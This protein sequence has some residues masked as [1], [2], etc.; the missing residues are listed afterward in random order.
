MTAG[1]GFSLKVT[2]LD[3]FGN[4]ATNYGGTA[5]LTSSGQ[6]VFPS[7]VS[8]GSFGETP[9]VAT[10]TAILDK[11]DTTTLT[12]TA[13]AVKGTS[14]KITVNPAAAASFVVSA[15][16]TVPVGTTFTITITVKD[17]L[18]NTDTNYIDPVQVSFTSGQTASLIDGS[19]LGYAFVDVTHGTGTGT[20]TPETAG[21]F[22]LN[23]TDGGI[24]ATSQSI[25]VGP[26]WFYNNIPDPGIQALRANRLR[27]QHTP[28]HQ[29]RRY[30]GPVRPGGI[31]D[32]QHKH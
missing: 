12:A 21:S 23:L 16:S 26:D 32:P 13:G 31:R 27:Q 2:A 18:G 7:T 9:G 10:V 24:T 4:V 3:A 30:V 29:L 25:T 5:T 6:T 8:F 14:N 1:A 22:T 11:A 17:Q 20:V 28:I 15:P 19:S